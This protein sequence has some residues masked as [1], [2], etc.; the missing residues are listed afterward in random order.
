MKILFAGNCQV[1]S[2]AKI[3]SAAEPKFVCD[4]KEVWQMSQEDCE[5]ISIADYDAVIA[6]PLVSERYGKLTQ[7]RLI[8]A[9]EGKSLL[10][11]HNLHFEGV[12]PDCT[13]VGPLGKRLNGPMGTYHSSIIL[14]AFLE[15]KSV[16]KC[17]TLLENGKSLD[18]QTIWDNSVASLRKREQAVTVKFVDELIMHVKAQ[19]CFHVFN[20]PNAFLLERYAEKIL[21]TLLDQP[22]RVLKTSQPDI[23]EPFGTWPIYSWLEKAQHLT[24]GQESFLIPKIS[25]NPLTLDEFVK[26]SYAIYSKTDKENLVI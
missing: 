13:Y 25:D 17:V 6:Q 19:S 15:G 3:T 11:I 10:F 8:T 14:N 4:A 26:R 9:C 23:L 22:E 20:H 5:A 16:T 12:V 18:V 1:T 2:L 24:Y 21:A 7:H